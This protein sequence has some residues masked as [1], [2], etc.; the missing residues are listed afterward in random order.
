MTIMNLA[1]QII[2]LGAIDT[3]LLMLLF[4]P[5]GGQWAHTPFGYVCLSSL[6]EHGAPNFDA[7]AAQFCILA[8]LTM[9]LMITFGRCNSLGLER[10]RSLRA[11][12]HGT[13]IACFMLVALPWQHVE[14]P[15]KPSINPF[16]VWSYR[17]FFSG[18]TLP[19]YVDSPYEAVNWSRLFIQLAVVAWGTNVLVSRGRARRGF[20]DVKA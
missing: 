16:R 9:M 3:A 6:R 12:C 1:Q 2:I 5:V 15:A 18:S 20:A 10:R 17:P 19:V 11:M 7:L 8:L 14:G 13:A 4:P